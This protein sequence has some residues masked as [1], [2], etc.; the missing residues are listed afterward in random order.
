[1]LVQG[2]EVE[3][4]SDLDGRRIGVDGGAAM[5]TCELWRDGPEHLVDQAGVEEVLVERRAA[6][7]E[8]AADAELV[9]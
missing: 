2:H 3:A 7:R 4:G 8:Q 9:V 6:L 1:M 5:A